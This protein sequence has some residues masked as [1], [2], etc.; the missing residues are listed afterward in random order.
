MIHMGE[1]ATHPGEPAA[2]WALSGWKTAASAGAAL[3]LSI[4]FIV[5]GVWKITDPFGA[6]QRLAQAHVPANLSL[7]AACMFGVAETFA[8]VLLFVPQF[9]RWGAWL[10][11]LLLVA[12]MV[13][14]GYYYNVLRG[15]ECNC[16]PWVRRAVGPAFFAGDGVMLALAVIARRW[17][18]P[19][20]SLR[21]ALLVLMAVCVFAAV[22]FGVGARTLEHRTAPAEITVNGGMVSLREGRFLIYFFDPECTH[23]NQAARDMAHLGWVGVRIIGVPTEQPQFARYFMDSTGLG[24]DISNDV[25]LLRKAFAFSSPPYAVAVENGRQKA[26]LSDFGPRPMAEQLREIGFIR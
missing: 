12:F 23:C 16:F 1:S 25:V 4:L 5:A 22:S 17:A 26:A 10:A 8:G 13:Y 15:E 21:G 18:R 2:L 11:G 6:A 24:G 3:L 9:R 14:I 19:S 7:A 20:S